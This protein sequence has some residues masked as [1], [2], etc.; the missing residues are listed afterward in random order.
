MQFEESKK[1]IQN[2][3]NIP[4]NRFNIAQNRKERKDKEQKLIKELEKI[5]IPEDVLNLAKDVLNTK[6]KKK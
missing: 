6:E 2:W 3:D 4:T 1:F 5:N